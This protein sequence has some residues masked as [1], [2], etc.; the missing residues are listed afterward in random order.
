MQRFAI[1]QTVHLMYE[2]VYLLLNR[3]V[4][5]VD[6]DYVFALAP[7]GVHRI[8]LRTTL[9]QPQQRH[10]LRRP[11]RCRSR[12]T[13]IFVQEQGHM[14]SPV[15]APQWGQERLEVATASLGTRQQ[16]PRTRPQ[17]HRPEDHPPCIATTEPDGGC[18]ATL[19]PR[20]T[21]GRKK[22]QVGLILGEYDATGRQGANLSPNPPFFSR[23]GGRVPAGSGA[24]SIHSP[25]APAPGGWY[26]RRKSCRCDVATPAGARVP[27]NS[28]EH[29][30]V[31]AE[32][33]PATP[34]GSPPLGLSSEE[35][36]PREAHRP[37]HGAHRNECR[38]RPNYRRSAESRRASGRWRQRSDLHRTPRRPTSG[39]RGEGLGHVATVAGD[40]AAANGLGL[41]G[42]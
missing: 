6:T 7:Q 24:A 25:A 10:A 39:D 22:Q 38:L 28:P 36:G 12:V 9:G 23:A 41:T 32:S 26:C 11:Q 20:G 40:D 2:Q 15:A 17:I 21:Q 13:G 4:L 27:S 16:Q 1:R 5:F 34:A 8:Q 37:A 3:R 31:P 19:T 14:P 35:G 18:L 29:S 42:S 33:K 30:R